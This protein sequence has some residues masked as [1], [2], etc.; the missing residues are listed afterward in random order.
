M[1]AAEGQ[2]VVRSLQAELAAK[3]SLGSQVTEHLAAIR[4]DLDSAAEAVSRLKDAQA[5]SGAS[6]MRPEALATLEMKLGAARAKI[7]AVPQSSSAC[8]SAPCDSHK[9]PTAGGRRALTLWVPDILL[10]LPLP[11]LSLLD[12]ER[13]LWRYLVVLILTAQG[14]QC[15]L[16]LWRAWVRIPGPM[17]DVAEA[18]RQHALRVGCPDEEVPR[19]ASQHRL[20]GLVAQLGSSSPEAQMEA[21]RDLVQQLMAPKLAVSERLGGYRW[22]D[23]DGGWVPVPHSGGGQYFEAAEEASLELEREVAKP[24]LELLT[25]GSPEVQ[26]L[27]GGAVAILAG[28]D[29]RATSILVDAGAIPILVH[30]LSHGQA[31]A[32][33]NAAWALRVLAHED[34]GVHREG[35]LAAGALLP[36]LHL[37]ETG[38]P[39]A[40]EWSRW[41]LR[42]LAVLPE[43]RDRLGSVRWAGLD[44]ASS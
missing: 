21:A 27:A 9:A 7:A 41:A 24:L 23:G 44:T 3:S 39:G 6:P 38:L 19:R 5:S 18:R 33:E 28:R 16:K 15:L 37:A 43:I 25:N 14:L 22:Q 17:V 29:S 13:S 4:Q 32:Q 2:E 34:D 30:V 10:C 11:I 31:E 26:R 35:I 8:S 36:L 12:P 1:R 20:P 40:K 42:D